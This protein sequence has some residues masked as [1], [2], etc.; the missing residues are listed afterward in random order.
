MCLSPG[1]TSSLLSRE[2]GEALFLDFVAC[3][4]NKATILRHFTKRELLPLMVTMEC[5]AN[6][7]EERF[8]ST[9]NNNMD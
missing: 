9:V 6:G 5:T 2:G 8:V 3:G 7:T 4:G 1:P